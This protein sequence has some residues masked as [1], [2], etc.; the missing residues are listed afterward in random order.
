MK[1]KCGFSQ[2]VITPEPNES[3]IDGFGSR[4]A[5]GMGVQD[6]I[7][8]K[9]CAISWEDKKF[10]IVSF[11]ICGFNRETSTL[12][13]NHI[14]RL[15]GMEESNIAL[16]CS[17]TH[18]GPAMGVLFKFSPNMVYCERVAYLVAYAVK[19]AFENSMDG[20]FSFGLGKELYYIY[21]RAGRDDIDRNVRVGGFYDENG[22]L[23]GVLASSSCHPTTRTGKD[24]DNHGTLFS[25]DYPGMMTQAMKTDYPD[26]PVLFL[27]GRGGDT[28]ALHRNEWPNSYICSRLGLELADSIRGVLEKQTAGDQSDYTPAYAYDR[29]RIPRKSLPSPE[30]LESRLEEYMQEYYGTTEKAKQ[31][32]LCGEMQWLRRMIEWKKAGKSPDMDVPFQVL[33]LSDR[34]IF[35]FFPYELLATT[36]HYIEEQLKQR[37]FDPASIFILGYVNEVYS[38]LAPVKYFDQGGYDIGGSR[39]AAS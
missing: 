39:G 20:S 35:L 6:D 5:T 28:N 37:G 7:M 38:Y 10:A 17:H 21:N 4:K 34:C 9:V 23:K 22:V 11:D 26:V 16:C 25:A 31:H 30:E 29:P 32:L 36:G 8:S 27:Q 33:K 24:S 14:A 3:F 18:A 2:V 13:K 15:N 19:D 1:I 12:I